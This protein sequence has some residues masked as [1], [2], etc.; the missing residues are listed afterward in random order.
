[1]HNTNVFIFYPVAFDL[2]RP[3]GDTYHCFTF[4]GSG[5]N[6]RAECDTN[7]ESEMCYKRKYESFTT[8][9]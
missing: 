4:Y 6:F 2:A 9:N 8:G 3:E 5:H 7:S 1:M